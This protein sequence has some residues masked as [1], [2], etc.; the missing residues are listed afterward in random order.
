VAFDTVDAALSDE[1]KATWRKVVRQLVTEFRLVTYPPMPIPEFGLLHGDEPWHVMVDDRGPQ[2][3]IEFPNAYQLSHA[4]RERISGRLG[5]RVEESDLRIPVS[6]RARQLLE[7]G[8][9]PVSPRLAGIF[10]LDLAILGVSKTRAVEVSLSP[11]V[12]HALGMATHLPS[13]GKMEV[14][15]DRFS[16]QAGTDWLMCTTVTSSDFLSERRSGRIPARL[17]HPAVGRRMPSASGSP[18]IPSGA[19][20]EPFPFRL[21]R[22]GL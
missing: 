10:A 7:A 22:N 9:V 11:A 6:R 21:N 2:I 13:A 14:W 17:Q 20:L 1:Q 5:T 19:H 8:S 4:A 12:L 3:T 15:G 16:H 18:G